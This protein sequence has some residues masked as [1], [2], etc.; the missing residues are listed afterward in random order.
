MKIT[1]DGA[2]Y[3]VLTTPDMFTLN[4]DA[5]SDY[6]DALFF[7]DQHGVIRDV[8]TQRPIATTEEQLDILISKLDG[9][10]DLM[11]NRE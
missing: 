10:R 8:V 5:Y 3:E 2:E 11:K 4:D 6:F 7:Q 1:F 9:L